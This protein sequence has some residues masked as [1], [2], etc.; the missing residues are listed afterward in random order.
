MEL[1]RNILFGFSV[2]SL[3]VAFI[4]ATR[5][6]VAELEYPVTDLEKHYH[7]KKIRGLAYIF[8]TTTLVGA[9]SLLATLI[10]AL[11]VVLS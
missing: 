3:T 9:L 4:F 2:L 7:R 6:E 1:L 11:C 5:L 8:V 10:I